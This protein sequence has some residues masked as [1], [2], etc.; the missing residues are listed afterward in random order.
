MR[1]AEEI[2]EAFFSKERVEKLLKK[3]VDNE[4]YMF[5]RRIVGSYIYD[6]LKAKKPEDRCN[7]DD[8]IIKEIEVKG[9]YLKKKHNR[10]IKKLKFLLSEKR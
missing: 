6:K 10:S 8:K 1:E 4:A 3:S 9:G 5:F 2:R 7:T